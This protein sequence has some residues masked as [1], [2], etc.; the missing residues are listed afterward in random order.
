M[1]KRLALLLLGFGYMVFVIEALRTAVAWWRGE[2]AE[3]GV[4]DYLLLAALP[5]LAWVWWRYL[6][7]FRKDCGKAGCGLPKE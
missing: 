7:V 6:S 2:L 5:A 3:R 1:R 4:T